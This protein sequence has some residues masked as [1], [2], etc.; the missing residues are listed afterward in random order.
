[1]AKKEKDKG[2]QC[3]LS[4]SHNNIIPLPFHCSWHHTQC[5]L[6]WCQAAALPYQ[7]VELVEV[8]YFHSWA[9]YTLQ[10]QAWVL[11]WRQPVYNAL[12]TGCTKVLM[13]SLHRSPCDVSVGILDWQSVTIWI[14]LSKIEKRLERK[15]IQYRQDNWLWS[16]SKLCLC[17]QHLLEFAL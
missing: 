15:R 14:F 7:P 6:V 9:S 16:V 4:S 12:Q 10:L 5:Q 13:L 2:W 1:M 11:R 17:R 8:C 3:T